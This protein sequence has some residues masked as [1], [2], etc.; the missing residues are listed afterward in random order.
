MGRYGQAAHRVGVA[1]QALDPGHSA[2]H[3]R[4][5]EVVAHRGTLLLGEVR[6][7]RH[8]RADAV[9][10][11]LRQDGDTVRA[12]P[13][14]GGQRPAYLRVPAPDQ[15]RLQP[16]RETALFERSPGLGQH[17]EDLARHGDAGVMAKQRRRTHHVVG[18]GQQPL[19]QRRGEVVPPG[20]AGGP[21]PGIGIGHEA[22]EMVGGEPGQFGG[23][24]AG[25]AGEEVV[26]QV[27]GEF[28]APGAG[29]RFFQRSSSNPGGRPPC[30]PLR[31][32]AAWLSVFSGIVWRIPCSRRGRQPARR[33]PSV[34]T[35]PLAAG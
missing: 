18:V 27:H 5:V 9:V 16:G 2:R 33:C 13:W 32:R 25:R 8:H 28:D 6:S 31:R 29:M 7:Q 15:L 17:G 3:R 10:G 34:G 19:P 24:G 11:V 23:L 14:V 12:E 21:H 4:R 1:V 20:E 30:E 22:G 35:A 26:V